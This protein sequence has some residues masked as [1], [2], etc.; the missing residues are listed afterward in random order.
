M[1]Q[2]IKNLYAQI[3]KKVDFLIELANDLDKSPNTMRNH[4]FGNF[5][6]IPEEYQERVVELLQNRIAL[7]NESKVTQ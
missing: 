2:N 3:D 7:Q 1:I 6:S 5:W 4:W